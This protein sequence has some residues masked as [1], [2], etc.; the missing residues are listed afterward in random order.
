MKMNL[1][2]DD[3]NLQ[4]SEFIKRKRYRDAIACC[5]KA[6]KINPKDVIALHAKG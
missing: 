1:P 2:P 3:W 4:A 5:N 6:I